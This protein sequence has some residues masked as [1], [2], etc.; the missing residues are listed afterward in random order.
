MTR[1]WGQQLSK[2][3]RS[4]KTEAWL[5]SYTSLWGKGHEGLQFK[6]TCPPPNGLETVP[7]CLF[8]LC[9]SSAVERSGVFSSLLCPLDF[10]IPE[11][12]NLLPWGLHDVVGVETEGTV[13]SPVTALGNHKGRLPPSLCS[14]HRREKARVCAFSSWNC[15]YFLSRSHCRT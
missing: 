9:V 8:S 12:N 2:A 3:N 1:G 13:D 5:N 10:C 4:R 6:T 14:V 15:D 11:D 7:T